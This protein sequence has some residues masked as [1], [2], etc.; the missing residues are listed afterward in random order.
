M[1]KPTVEELHELG[2]STKYGT[3]EHHYT[4][5]TAKVSSMGFKF[6]Q[7]MNYFADKNIFLLGAVFYFSP[8]SFDELKVIVK[9]FSTNVNKHKDYENC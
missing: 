8:N 3:D 6:P 2:F 4:V 7:M 5:E 9:A 1:Y